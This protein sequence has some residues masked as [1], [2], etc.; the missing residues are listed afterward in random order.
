MRTPLTRSV[1]IVVGALGFNRTLTYVLSA[2]PYI[3]AMFV[4]YFNGLHADKKGERTWHIVTP[5][6]VS[7]IANIIALSTTKTAPRYVAMVLLPSS[8]YSSNILDFSWISA[9]MTGSHNKRAV[10]FAFVNCELCPPSSRV[11]S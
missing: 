4:L 3:V 8:I 11:Q 5:F 7:V 10:V 6:M 2:P 1:T 9:N